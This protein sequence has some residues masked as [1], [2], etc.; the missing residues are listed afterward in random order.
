MNEIKKEGRFPNDPLSHCT[1]ASRF[2]IEFPDDFAWATK[3]KDSAAVNYC[4]AIAHFKLDLYENRANAVS[5]WGQSIA[6][7]QLILTVGKNA[8]EALQ[9][10]SGAMGTPLNECYHAMSYDV[11]TSTKRRIIKEAIYRDYL[12]ETAASWNSRIKLIYP[13]GEELRRFLQQQ[14]IFRGVA[15]HHN[16][17]KYNRQI[18]PGDPLMDE[19]MDEEFAQFDF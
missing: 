3:N 5:F 1:R 13:T 10:K 9:N 2:E 7:A 11:S 18:E 4:L 12:R 19:I 8:L 16:L 14:L 6:H 17:P 15:Q